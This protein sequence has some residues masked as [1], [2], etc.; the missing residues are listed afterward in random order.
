MCQDWEGYGQIGEAEWF[1]AADLPDDAR[2]H[3]MIHFLFA[4]YGGGWEKLDTFRDGPGGTAR[5]VALAPGVAR[6]P[7]ALLAHPNGGALAV[8]AHVDRAWS[9]SFRTLN[10]ANQNSGL[11]EVVRC[12]LLGQRIGSATDRF[13]M[14]WGAL[15]APLA[16]AMR[17]ADPSIATARRIARLWIARDDARNYTILGD[18][19]V[20]LRVG[21]MIA[22]A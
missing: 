13:N 17:A 22:A 3:G 21:D 16:D 11:R 6:L 18:P 2:M 12:L 19:A 9:Y 7:Q 8:L 15:A 5:Q 20:R 1:A 10:N 4:C 14:Q